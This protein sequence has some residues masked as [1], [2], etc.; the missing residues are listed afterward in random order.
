MTEESYPGPE[1]IAVVGMAARFPG[2]PDVDAFWRNLRGGVE[3]IARLT[4]EEIL[5]SGA[6]ADL[7][8]RPDFVRAYGVLDE[9]DLFDPDFFDLTPRDAELM[10]PQHRLF[11]EQAWRALEHAGCDPSSF[12]G[13]IGVFGGSNL[14][15]YL[16]A[17]VARH[18]T[19]AADVLQARIRADKDFLTT[20]VSYKLDL[21]GPSYAVQTAC[22]TSLVAVHLACQSLIDFHC[23]MALAGGVS[24]GAPLR[25]GYVAREGVLSPDGHCRAFDARGEGT[26]E[27]AGVGVV[28]LKRLSDALADGDRVHAVILA[29]AVNN[30]GAQ[31]VGFTA[32]SVEGQIEVVATAHAL[33]RVPAE[34]ITYVEAHGTATPMGD[35]VE[36]TALTQ[37]FGTES[38]GFCAL[39]SVKTN[40]GHLDAAAGVAS[41]I[42]AVLALEHGEIP[43]SLHFEE[44]NPEIDFAGSP[45]YV[46]DR[47]L[48]WAPP[49]GVPRRAGVSS[50]GIG[51]TNAH[52]VLEEAPREAVRR[53][54]D[55]PELLVLSARTPEALDAL[56][57][58]TAERLESHPD[59]DPGDLAFTLQQGRRAF[60][61]R[62]A[63]VAASAAEAAALLRSADPA[64]VVTAR[65][66]ELDPGV[67]FLFSGLGTQY[68]GMGRELYER[69]PV[70]R[71][72]MDRCFAILRDRWGMDLREKLY[73]AATPAP[74]AAGSG[75]DLRAMLRGTG[76]PSEGDPLQGARWG[77]PAMFAVGWALAETW[78]SR[79]IEPRAVAGHSLGEYVAACVA[80][81]FSLED[82]LT[83]VV[84]RAELLEPIRGSMAAVGL[85]EAEVRAVLADLAAEGEAPALA[86]V[87]APRSCVVSGTAE[88]VARFA[89][90]M[91]ARGETV[92]P[93][94]VLHPFHSPLLEPT[95]EELARVL[96]GMRRNAPE[97]PL[98]ANATG[99]WLRPEEA[100]SV[101]YWVE[102]LTAPVRFAECVERLRGLAGNAGEPVLLEL[103]PG[104]VLGSWARQQGAERVASSLRH[105]EQGGSDLALLRRAVGQLW[106][107]GVPVDW[108][109]QGDTE[110]RR[111]VVLP[112][113]PMSRRRY[114]LLDVPATQAAAG[115]P[116]GRLSTTRWRQLPD[117]E[118]AGAEAFAGER[119]V[120]FGGAGAA[121]VASR[122]HAAGAGPVRVEAG[123]AFRDEGARCTVRPG[124]PGDFVRL[125][126]ALRA[127]GW[128]GPVHALHLWCLDGDAAEAAVDAP[129]L[130]AEALAGAG[131]PGEGS[132]LLAATRGARAVLGTE[133]LHPAQAPVAALLPEAARALP[134]VRVRAVDVEAR[135]WEEAV[136]REAADLRADDARLPE[137]AWR[138]TG[139][140]EPFRAP[141]PAPGKR[142]ARTRLR[143]E[144]VYLVAGGPGG[145]V[146]RHRPLPDGDGPGAGVAGRRRGRRGAGRGHARR[147]RGADDPLLPGGRRRGRGLPG[148]L[149]RRAHPWRGGSHRGRRLGRAGRRRP[150]RGDRPG[151]GRGA[152]RAPLRPRHRD[153]GDGA[154]GRLRPRPGRGRGGPGAPRAPRRGPVRGSP[155]RAGA[156]AGGD[157]RACAGSGADRR[158]RRLLR[159][160]R[161]LAAGDS[162]PFRAERA[163]PGGAPAA[164]ALRGRH[165]GPPGRGDRAAADG[166]GGRR[167][168]RPRPRRA[169]ARRE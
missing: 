106:C 109:R 36:V 64:E 135:A 83:L 145:V 47:L 8:S 97:V 76:G 127:R 66:A 120:V 87:N 11:L 88:A 147:G 7:L 100:R 55:G 32:P 153:A 123:D 33:A 43:P 143:E 103:G 107:W 71:A 39:G 58:A 113:H 93:L 20:L 30:D 38:R 51:G 124:E 14:N 165:P 92:L 62:R 26:V 48:P 84:R 159:A 117:A 101:E 110:G 102:H 72:A 104:A 17:L 95:R 105:G 157:V 19:R 18:G 80:G 42:K 99:R 111:R 161:R 122:L 70:F 96:A 52:V 69:E 144:G 152:A 131:F 150:L 73:G 2:A 167:P 28:A 24:V 44:P 166:P 119:V 126:E 128:D 6:D 27:A 121:G 149:R 154:R 78:R 156:D 148:H 22:S 125:A 75:P 169:V 164:R 137:V 90:R 60:P 45:F 53:R 37:A 155:H 114:W 65:A 98:A 163:L 16:L 79:G 116:E 91:R 10:D 140:W 29:S 5:A 112:G 138:G 46:A 158:G 77:H 1:R 118:D 13:P 136:L 82:A 49:A 85:P 94:A 21:R 133:E 130:W 81:V 89:E 162:A 108:R 34:S 67:A 168:A 141:L 146:A 41:L 12:P 57:A 3:S 50:F 160:G 142:G 134:G 151:G 31:K 35:P 56:S 15:S 40:V 54:G 61:H 86:A 59:L 23:D 25:G 9:A 74:G 139:R 68:A 115:A 132:T 4:D 129:R 63:L